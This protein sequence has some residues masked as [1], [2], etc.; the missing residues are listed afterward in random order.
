L[1]NLDVLPAGGAT[2]DEDW[3]NR[4]VRRWRD[5]AAVGIGNAIEWYDWGAYAIFSVFF[6]SRFFTSGDP[7]ADLLKALA[8]FAVGFVARPFGGLLFGWFADRAGRQPAMTLAVALAAAGSLVIGVTPTVETIGVGAPIVLLTARLLQGLAYGGELPA[9]QTY[10][11]E[12]APRKRRG[13][14]ASTIY[15]SG[16][17]GGLAGTLLGAVCTQLLSRDQMASFGW[18]IP[19]L[20]GG[21][22]GLFALVMRSQLAETETFRRA[23]PVQSPRWRRILARPVLLLRVVGITGGA[24]ITVYVWSFGE[25]SFAI[26]QRGTNPASALWIGSVAIV[27]FTIALPLWAVLSDRIGRRPVMLISFV[28]LAVLFFPLQ[29]LVQGKAWQLLVATGISMILIAGVLSIAPAV[30][31]E[32]FPTGIRAIGFGVPYSVTVAL[33][34]GTAPYLQSYFN[35]HH[36]QSVFNWWVILL[37][38]ISVYTVLRLPES[39]A[40]DLRQL[41]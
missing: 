13:L 4:P 14:W 28:L 1:G 21:I 2:E 18:R 27:I 19:F 15:L 30:Y 22:L 25:T 5:L 6:A 33:F 26:S 7:R 40:A 41:P 29:N 36:N 34:G 3:A 23:A 20:L 31:A 35:L 16:S 9:A 24:T 37:I 17:L 8:V 38:A 39:R 32:I 12:V 11:A 10:L